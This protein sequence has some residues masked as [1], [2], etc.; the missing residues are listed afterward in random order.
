M[1]DLHTGVRITNCDVSDTFVEDVPADV[2]LDRDWKATDNPKTP[3]W[4]CLK[5]CPEFVIDKQM[6]CK[7]L[8]RYVHTIISANS[9]FDKALLS[10]AEE[11]RAAN[12]IGDIGANFISCTF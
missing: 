11:L 12:G 9:F 3:V 5:K 8:F 6:G 4:E 1:I 10:E 2:F 7:Q